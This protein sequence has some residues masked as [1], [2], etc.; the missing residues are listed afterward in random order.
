MH[1]LL[2][3]NK[4]ITID[5]S[6]IEPLTARADA[7]RIS[8]VI[9][10]LISN[11][12]K[13]SPAGSTVTVTAKRRGDRACVSVKDQGRASRKTSAAGCSRSL[14]ACPRARP[15]ARRAPAWGWRFPSASLR[16]T[17]GRSASRTGRAR[18]PRSG[19]PSR[20]PIDQHP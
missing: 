5:G 2:A 7:D 9:D 13:Y 3:S 6:H 15:A 4:A 14:A 16:R 20:S 12:V 8:Q 11:A 17:A 1:R 19:L 18:G 10:N